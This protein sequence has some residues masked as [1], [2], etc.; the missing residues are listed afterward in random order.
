MVKLHSHLLQTTNI[1]KLKSLTFLSL[2]LITELYVILPN[3]C[4]NYKEYDMNVT[5]LCQILFLY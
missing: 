4:S 1:I 3:Q 2:L 5:T